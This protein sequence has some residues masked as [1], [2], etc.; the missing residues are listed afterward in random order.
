MYYINLKIS[1]FEL[2]SLTYIKFYHSKSFNDSR[3]SENLADS[4]QLQ[5]AMAPSIIDSVAPNEF[6][7]NEFAPNDFALNVMVDP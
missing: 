1:T 2:L 5:I 3:P 6:A 4:L 7:S